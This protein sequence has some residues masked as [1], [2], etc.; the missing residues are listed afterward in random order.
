MGSYC[1]GLMEEPLERRRAIAKYTSVML[2]KPEMV[3]LQQTA[4]H[5]NAAA[6]RIAA[7]AIWN[8]D[9]S[10]RKP[11]SSNIEV[12]PHPMNWII[13]KS[14]ELT[15]A[16]LIRIKHSDASSNRAISL[17]MINSCPVASAGRVVT[18]TPEAFSLRSSLLIP[19]VAKYPVHSSSDNLR[20]ILKS[21]FTPRR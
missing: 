2:R 13:P 15:L 1:E 17:D 5:S 3:A 20:I 9:L 6:I 12:V 14:F 10:K 19:H 18:V 21:E 11:G 8:S 4:L 16:S 7:F